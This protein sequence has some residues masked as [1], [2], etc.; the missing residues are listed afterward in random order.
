VSGEGPSE[1]VT[2]F[3]FADRPL[4]VD[5]RWPIGTVIA[6]VHIT[7]RGQ[8]ERFACP[9]S[10]GMWGPRALQH[11]YQVARTD[12]KGVWVRVSPEK[13]TE[14]CGR[15]LSWRPGGFR[16]EL[17]KTGDIHDGE[18]LTV[19]DPLEFRVYGIRRGYRTLLIR[20]RLRYDGQLKVRVLSGEGTPHPDRVGGGTNA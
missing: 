11:H 10:G 15:M 1:Y 13:T 5:S 17:V 6:S 8:G 9:A 16:I 7:P 19:R 12:L 20:E 4:V 3:R 18:L 14:T 2:D